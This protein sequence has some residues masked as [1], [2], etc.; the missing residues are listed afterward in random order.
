MMR[1][2]V[3]S[4]LCS[5]TAAAQVQ[6]F[7]TQQLSMLGARSSLLPES[8]Q[9]YLPV[10]SEHALNAAVALTTGQCGQSHF[11]QSLNPWGG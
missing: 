8:A 9:R 6:K 2:R 7:T 5:H 1:M 11:I 3:K 4:A 10:V